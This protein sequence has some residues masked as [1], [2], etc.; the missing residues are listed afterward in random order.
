M[1]MVLL[2]I[3]YLFSNVDSPTWYVN[4]FQLFLTTIGYKSRVDA[5]FIILG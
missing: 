4:N 5:F 2:S 3:L 1:H